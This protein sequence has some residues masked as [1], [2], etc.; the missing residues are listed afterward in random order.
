MTDVNK[1][2]FELDGVGGEAR[3]PNPQQENKAAIA[4]GRAFKDALTGGLVL[5]AA[6]DRHLRDQGLW[7]D[8]RQAEYDVVVK[9]L[10][11]NE[12]LLR[13]GGK[14]N[15][16]KSQG[17]EIAVAMRVDRARLALMRRDHNDLDLKTAEAHAEQRKFDCL[18]AACSYDADG[19][20]AF[21]SE[22]D[23]AARAN[24]PL[25]ERYALEFAKLYYG[26]DDEA[27]GKKPEN[28]FLLAHGYVDSE[29]RLVDRQGNLIDG[30]GNPVDGQGRRV[31]A[32][33]QLVDAEGNAFD[34]D[35]NYIVESSPFLED[36]GDGDC[37]PAPKDESPPTLPSLP[38][39]PEDEVL[40]PV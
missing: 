31:N 2:I 28:A 25:R 5:R 6:L 8:A 36:E 37:V 7:D 16:T 35:G 33:G 20:H 27:E 29:L 32:E 3:R 22:D 13:Q 1:R 4:Y 34:E 10:F 17:R 26:V 9:R 11:A 15:L 18:V 40:P 19:R 30:D 38:D 23:Y 24:E 12:R 14:A 21:A 39:S